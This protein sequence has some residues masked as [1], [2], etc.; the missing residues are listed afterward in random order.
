[1]RLEGDELSFTL[2]KV[3]VARVDFIRVYAAHNEN[4]TEK[5]QQQRNEQEYRVS[6]VW[7]C[8]KR[9]ERVVHSAKE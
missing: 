7:D 4:P 9:G 6:T 5:N 8:G 2:Y 1:M 3:H